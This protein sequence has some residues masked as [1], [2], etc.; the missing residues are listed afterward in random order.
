MIDKILEFREMCR[1][2]GEI[3]KDCGLSARE[4]RCIL[5]VA[6]QG[7][8]SSK[9]LSRLVDLSPSR[10]SRVIGHLV[11]RGLILVHQN[12][13]DRRSVELSL[14]EE[15]EKCRRKIEEDKAKCEARLLASLTEEE[16]ELVQNGLDLLIKAL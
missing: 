8:L 16:R 7:V 3:G 2:E 5:T 4:I 13:Q 11:D 15:G 1:L 9:D 10:G 6:Q 14:S 12:D